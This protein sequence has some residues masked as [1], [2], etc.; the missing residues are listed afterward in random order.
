MSRVADR[1]LLPVVASLFLIAVPAAAFA[2]DIGAQLGYAKAHDAKS[3]NGLV[4]GH[5]EIGLTPFLG[6]QGAVDYRLVETT[7]ISA[8]VTQG[9][10]KVRSVPTTVTAR[11]YLPG[12]VSPF[13]AVGAGW[14]HL[15]YDYSSNLQALG[16]S[17]HAETTFGWHV[18]GGVRVMV[19][20]KVSVYG[21]GRAVFVRP[22]H[23]LNQQVFDQVKSWDYDSV[24]FATGVSLHL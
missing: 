13:A 8:G 21:E 6:I 16:A 3:G 22:D 5:L 7:D 23:A 14:Y 17:D 15:V 18:G 20:P 9:T 11:L 10:L 2:S 1:A 12:P 19:A 24:Y 4:G